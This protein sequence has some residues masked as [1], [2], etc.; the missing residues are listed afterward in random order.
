MTVTSYIGTQWILLITVHLHTW[1]CSPVTAHCHY[2]QCCLLVIVAVY[3]DNIRQTCCLHLQG[4]R[5]QAP[6]NNGTCFYL[7][8]ITCC[9]YSCT[10]YGLHTQYMLLTHADNLL[11]LQQNHYDLFLFILPRFSF[12]SPQ[13]L[14]A[15]T[16]QHPTT[17][18]IFCMP[19]HERL[20][21]YTQF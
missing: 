4:G 2:E 17:L 19:L 20:W 9:V 18:P 8:M 16:A 15:N 13:S 12:G 6:D 21:F 3:C 5:Q 7:M 10:Q 14:P 1:I 11:C